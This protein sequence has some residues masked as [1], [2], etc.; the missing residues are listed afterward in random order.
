MS[1]IDE[2]LKRYDDEKAGIKPE[3]ST[4]E[5]A[6]KLA[7][8]D[9]LKKMFVPQSNEEEFRIIL[10]DNS[11]NHYEEAYFHEAKVNGQYKKLYCLKKNDGK[12]CP[13]CEQREVDFKAA[14]DA[15]LEKG[16]PESKAAFKGANVWEPKKF[17]IFKGVDKLRLADG[18]K[19]WRI[20]A[21]HENAG[22]YD[23]V[24]DLAGSYNRSTGNDF[25]DPLKGFDFKIKVTDMKTPTGNKYKGIK[26]IDQ[27]AM[28]P[29]AIHTSGKEVGQPDTTKI[30]ELLADT[31]TWREVF[32]PSSINNLLNTYQY[33]QSVMEDRVPRWDSDKKRFFRKDENGVEVELDLRNLQSSDATGTLTNAAATTAAIKAAP[34][35]ITK[36]S[37]QEATNIGDDDFGDLPF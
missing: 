35:K 10:P 11:E 26:R 24:I 1:K 34:S 37:L 28:S 7:G 25:A 20:K 32:G 2:L 18:L 4:T 5:S 30:A 23:D 9:K 16:S 13:M 6:G 15:K 33:L 14:L 12:P 21:H 19:F 17:Y 29:L 27:G 3:S 8:A 22:A 36:Q 31:M